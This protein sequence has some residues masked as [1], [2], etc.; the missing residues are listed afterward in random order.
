MG[1]QLKVKLCN[2]DNFNHFS[3]SCGCFFYFQVYSGRYQNVVDLEKQRLVVESFKITQGFHLSMLSQQSI[4]WGVIVTHMLRNSGWQI[5]ARE[6]TRNPLWPTWSHTMANL[7]SP[8]PP[9]LPHCTREESEGHWKI[10]RYATR[11]EA[12]GLL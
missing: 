2:M 8:I 11:Q 3:P 6:L 9:I 4:V 5:L 7:W 12:E 10:E 1:K